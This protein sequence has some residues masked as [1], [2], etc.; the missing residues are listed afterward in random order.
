MKD[1]LE[2][3]IEYINNMDNE[4][5]HTDDCTNCSFKK[6]CDNMYTNDNDSLA[7]ST[8]KILNEIIPKED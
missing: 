2:K 7:L 5:K 6:L 1:R 4:C 8:L 3:A